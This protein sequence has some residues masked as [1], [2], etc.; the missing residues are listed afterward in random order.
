MDGTSPSAGP[1]KQAK[2]LLLI[3]LNCTLAGDHNFLLKDPT[4][5]RQQD[6]AINGMLALLENQK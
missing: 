3:T 2:A 1:E 5:K 4:N 6:S